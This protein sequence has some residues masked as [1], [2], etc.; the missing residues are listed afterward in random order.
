MVITTEYSVYYCLAPSQPGSPATHPTARA[1][2]WRPIST[3]EAKGEHRTDHSPLIRP[4]SAPV[5]IPDASPDKSGKRL[6]GGAS[7][8]YLVDIYIEIR[9]RSQGRCPP[10]GDPPS[11]GGGRCP[12]SPMSGV[13]GHDRGAE[14]DV[15]EDYGA[16]IALTLRRRCGML[17]EQ[18]ACGPL[19][20][21]GLAGAEGAL[22]GFLYLA[23]LRCQ[24]Q[25][26][27]GGMDRD[28]LRA[29][30]WQEYA[31]LH[32]QIVEVAL[33]NGRTWQAVRWQECAAIAAATAQMHL[34]A[35][36]NR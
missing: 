34:L 30:E 33:R 5:P 24:S 23:A 28:E 36:I 26:T 13:S 10:R 2:P 27:E 32:H 15:S 7:L 8:G 22:S 6:P 1:T 3:A 14:R 4:F 18:S 21:G 35:L 9:P 19:Q 31:A 16:R 11:P 12:L 17:R 25:P 20:C 29:T